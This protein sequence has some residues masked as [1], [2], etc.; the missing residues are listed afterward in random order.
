MNETR[1]VIESAARNGRTVRLTYT[2]KKGEQSVRNVEPY[3]FR[4]NKLWAYC[5]KK[6][7][8]RQF[9][10][11]RI[12]KA[13]ETHYVYMPKWDVKINKGHEKTGSFYSNKLKDRLFGQYEKAPL[14]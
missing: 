4:D 13:K 7:G 3:E 14:E 1:S 11:N 12:E 8:I 6:K 5:R 9:D 10:L 2:D